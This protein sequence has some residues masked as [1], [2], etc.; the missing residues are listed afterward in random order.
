[1]IEGCKFIKQLI[2]FMLVNISIKIGRGIWP[3]LSVNYSNKVQ[4]LI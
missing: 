4:Y 3:K 2:K 1:M